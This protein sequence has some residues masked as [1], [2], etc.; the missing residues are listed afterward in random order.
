MLL[1]TGSWCVVETWRAME[2]LVAA[3]LAFLALFALRGGW[4][5]AIPLVWVFNIE[6]ILDMINAV[7]RGVLYVPAGHFGATY[8]IPAI[9][10]PALVVTHVIIFILLLR[11]KDGAGR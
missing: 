4:K 6:G 3:G 5:I 10:V 7:A 11:G 8:F 1:P 9:I 2:D